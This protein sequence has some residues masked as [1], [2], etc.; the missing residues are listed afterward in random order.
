MFVCQYRRIEHIVLGQRR[1]VVSTDVAYTG[2][3]G[4]CSELE[5]VQRNCMVLGSMED[6]AAKIT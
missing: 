3:A 4:G 1:E 5:P 6:F 2:N